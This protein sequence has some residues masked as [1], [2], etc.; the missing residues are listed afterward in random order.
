MEIRHARPED[1]KRIC[2]L[3]ASIKIDYSDPQK[4]GFLV[5]T[6]DEDGY[7]RR[8]R[9]DLFYVADN[10]RGI[11]GFLMCYDDDRLEHMVSGGILGHEDGIIGFVSRQ[12]R[13]Y[14][15][16]DQIGVAPE[17]T[18]S[19]IGSAMM[20]ELFRDMRARQI[21]KMYVAILDAPSRNMA[22]IDF[23]TRLGFIPLARVTNSDGKVWGIYRKDLSRSVTG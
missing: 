17:K 11:D 20:R 16:G 7:E 21:P 2:D 19:G 15:F 8:M 1:A 13:P 14:V 23:C 22:S 4:T 6:L 5:Y 12:E 3:A 9:S 10:G 18:A